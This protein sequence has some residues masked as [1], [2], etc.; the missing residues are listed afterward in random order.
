MWSP[1]QHLCGGSQM[2]NYIFLKSVNLILCLQ[3][4]QYLQEFSQKMISRT[5]EI[6]KEVDSLVHDA[7][8]GSQSF[9]WAKFLF[10]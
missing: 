8:V 3:L 1:G 7:K 5:H 9:H 6:E 4:L 2:G 10:V